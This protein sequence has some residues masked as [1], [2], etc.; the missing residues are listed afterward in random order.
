MYCVNNWCPPPVKYKLIQNGSSGTGPTGNVGPTGNI[1]DTGDIGITGYTGYTGII[2]EPGPTGE[3]GPTGKMGNTGPTGH[4]GQTGEKGQ[5]GQPGSVIRFC[6][7]SAILRYNDV[8]I[9]TNLFFKYQTA[10]LNNFTK[11]EDALIVEDAGLYSISFS[12]NSSNFINVNNATV[13]ILVN[14]VSVKSLPLEPGI[15]TMNISLILNENDIIRA[16]FVNNLDPSS[17][18]GSI[19]YSYAE[20]SVG[21]V[22]IFTEDGI[23]DVPEGACSMEAVVIGGGGKTLSVGNNAN[24][25][26]GGQ[27][28]VVE[29]KICLSG[30]T[31]VKATIGSGGTIIVAKGQP[32]ILELLDINGNI[33][34]TV[35]A[36]GGGAGNNGGGAS[37]FLS[38]SGGDGGAAGANRGG[39]GG[40]SMPS[41][42][43]FPGGNGGAGFNF[44]GGGGAGFG[45]NFGN[46][47][48]QTTAGGGGTGDSPPPSNFGGLVGAGPIVNGGSAL[49]GGGGGG[50]GIN[51][52]NGGNSIYGGGGGGGGRFSNGGNSVYGGGGGQGGNSQFGGGGGG[53]FDNRNGGRGGR[54]FIPKGVLPGIIPLSGNGGQPIG[55]TNGGGSGGVVI[56]G[57]ITTSTLQGAGYGAGGSGDDF[58]PG[59]SGLIY[60][61]FL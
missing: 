9:S 8:P 44:N 41:N 7:S 1:G 5:T 36:G 55:T 60:F 6:S 23:I 21:Q 52:G 59:R 54:G 11:S 56:D 18:I 46:D 31:Q 35:I 22:F 12:L 34:E 32:S 25:G 40:G 43:S 27:G 45:N 24:I 39:G 57:Y 4:T 10:D 28:A 49:T 16:I 51:S 29:T 15:L 13:D 50:R 53:A 47:A 38:Q 58:L 20:L 26:G 37:G 61:R 14:N 19:E 42:D 30:V 2:G 17:G 48:V 33:V 3:R